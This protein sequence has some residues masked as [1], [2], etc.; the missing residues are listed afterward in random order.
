MFDVVDIDLEK[1]FDRVNHDRL[2]G[3]LAQRIQDKRMLR[4]IRAFLEAGV[5]EDGLVSPTEEGTPQA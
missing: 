3:A 2:M 1:F 5:M 4:V